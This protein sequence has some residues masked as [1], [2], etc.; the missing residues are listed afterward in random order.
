M[1]VGCCMNNEYDTEE[2]RENPTGFVDH[3]VR[4]V[5]AEKPSVTRF[6]VC[7]GQRGP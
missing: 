6:D 3:I 1:R 7:L 2:L 4:N 5:L